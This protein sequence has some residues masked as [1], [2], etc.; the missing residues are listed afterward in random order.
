MC[1]ASE[2]PE[3]GVGEE[4]QG[5]PGEELLRKKEESFSLKDGWKLLLALRTETHAATNWFT[6]LDYTS[7][8][9]YYA[10]I[11]I[12]ITII[13]IRLL[14]KEQCHEDFAVLGQFGAKI[15]TLRLQS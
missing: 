9:G 13:I 4:G 3:E 7:F 6:R 11:T 8:C 2:N 5:R 15:I 14:L 12:I 10:I 1:W